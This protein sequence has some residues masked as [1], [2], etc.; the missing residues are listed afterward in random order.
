MNKMLLV[1]F[2]GLFS[3]QAANALKPEF[4]QLNP[5][6]YKDAFKIGYYHDSQSSNFSDADFATLFDSVLSFGFEA[7]MFDLTASVDSDGNLIH[8]LAY[9]RLLSVIELAGSKGLDTSIM[10]NWTFNGE[11]AQYVGDRERLFGEPLTAEFTANLMNSMQEFWVP[12]ATQ[13]NGAGLDLLSLGAFADVEFMNAEVLPKWQAIVADVRAVYGGA[14]TFTYLHILEFQSRQLDEVVI[15]DLFDVINIWTRWNI[16]TL[17]VSDHEFIQQSYVDPRFEDQPY[18]IIYKNLSEKYQL[19]LVLT[20]NAFAVSHALD[21]GWDPY[22]EELNQRPLD[23]HRDL[24]KIAFEASLH[25]ISHNLNDE[26]A[27]VVVGN[28]E[29]WANAEFSD[30]LYFDA[31]KELDLTLLPADILGVF[32]N[33]FEQGNHYSATMGAHGSVYS[34][35]LHGGSSNTAFYLNGGLDEVF[36]G[37]GADSFHLPESS[38]QLDLTLHGWTREDSVNIAEI[39][40]DGELWT[41]FDIAKNL[42]AIQ[43]S[44]FDGSWE[45]ASTVIPIDDPM[46]QHTLEIVVPSGPGTQFFAI[47]ELSLNGPFGRQEVDP[48]PNNPVDDAYDSSNWID[49]EQ[50]YSVS[51]PVASASDAI[52]IDGGGGIDTLVYPSA[53]TVYPQVQHTNIERIQ[54]NGAFALDYDGHTGFVTRLLATLLGLESAFHAEYLGIGLDLLASGVTEDTIANLAIEVVLGANPD[55]ASLANL[56]SNNLHGTEASAETIST[57]TSQ[58][59]SGET[60]LAEYLLDNINAESTEALVNAQQ[61]G[62]AGIPYIPVN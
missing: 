58:I 25:H 18:A 32:T 23:V 2:T 40:F 20:V 19:P 16:S 29:V 46:A 12:F 53:T 1:V 5:T 28:Y 55:I 8:I 26:V 44:G 6:L 50:A 52:V 51:L 11:N 42:D 34:E 62:D 56:I 49:D 3:L 13:L 31:W 14:L 61:F 36:G 4:S 43:N 22:D 33:Y 24:Q 10:V 59:E 38:T 30:S 9:D 47:T 45:P 57:L 27:S 37:S 54:S 39:Y 41:T 15:W 7:V 35:R 21:G 17:P 60:S 48:F